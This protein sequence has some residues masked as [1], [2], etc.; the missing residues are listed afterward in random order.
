MPQ[1]QQLPLPDGQVLPLLNTAALRRLE[2]DAASG[3]LMERAGL[4]VARLAKAVWPHAQRASVV[5]GPGNNGGDGLVAARL[6]QA[7]GLTVQWVAVGRGRRQSNERQ[8]AEAA[9]AAAGV[10]A[11][12]LDALDP[13]AD[14]LVDALLGIGLNLAPAGELL[15]AI[16][17][18]NRHPAPKLGVDLPS[19][20]QADTGHTPGA[21]VRCAHTLSLLGPT[22]GL[23]TGQ[24]R[25]QA[26]R[27]W[28][29]RLDCQQG[30][31]VVALAGSPRLAWRQLSARRRWP[32]SGHKGSAGRVW[33]LQGATE[34]AGAARLAARAALAAGAGRVYLAGD[35]IDSDPLWPELMR[36]QP[37]QALAEVVDGVGVVGCG[38]G[39]GIASDLSS[40]LVNA[41]QLVIDADALN[42]LAGSSGLVHALAERHLR[43]LRSVI[44]PHPLEAAR[45]LDT[46]TNDVQADRLKAASAL[47]ERMRCTV[48][49]KGSGSV[50]ATPGALPRINSSG[51]AALGTAGSGDVLA[52]WLGGL[53]AQ[54]PEAP[55]HD[56]AAIACAWQGEA[57]DRLPLGGGPLRASELISVMT[58]LQP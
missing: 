13:D 40:W 7:Q 31:S 34:M 3:Q 16:D 24:G 2:Q 53:M 30:E 46:T 1:L 35:A 14:F 49:L 48:I 29:D 10:R 17:A 54:A 15:A 42:A 6:L 28:L 5:C 43:G 26:G 45:L 36:R 25:Q 58:E 23:F 9:A 21:A 20:L 33:V 8:Q 12:S 32:H 4:A 22:P 51:H 11:V 56:L 38:G 57:A 18:I 52:G 27:L 19:G 39:S 47:A 44:T 50:I 55:T 41:A 37:A